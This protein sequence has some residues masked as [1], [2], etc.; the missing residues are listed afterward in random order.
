MKKISDDLYEICWRQRTKGDVTDRRSG[1]AHG[2]HLPEQRVRWSNFVVAVSAD[3][4]QVSD[5]VTDQELAEQVHRRR[6]HP[7]QVVQE[8]SK[9]VLGARKDA[10]EARK[11]EVKTRAR[12]LRWQLD[13]GWLLSNDQR[14]L[15]D[16]VNDEAPAHANASKNSGRQRLNS[17][18]GRASNG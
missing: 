8:Q 2:R 17:P 4:H 10:D 1:F 13:D 9:R 14:K 12:I 15:G 7:L 16:Q 11:H 18:S 3:Q 6:V 5:V